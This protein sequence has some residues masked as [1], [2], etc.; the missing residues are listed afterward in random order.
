MGDYNVPRVS[1]SKTATVS[2]TAKAI[3]HGDFGFVAAS[4]AQAERAV[5]TTR[6]AGAMVLWDGSTPT[7]TFGHLIDTTLSSP[8][9]LTGRVKINALLLIREAAVDSEVTITLE[10]F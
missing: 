4:L 10:Q 6:S 2:N 8:F 3:T 9:I 5:I 7:A 1:E